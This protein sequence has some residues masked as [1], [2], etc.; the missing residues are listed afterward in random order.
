M[1]SQEFYMFQ[2]PILF[3]AMVL[4][5]LKLMRHQEQNYYENSQIEFGKIMM[6]VSKLLKEAYRNS[7]HLIQIF[8][9]NTCIQICFNLVDFNR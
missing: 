3:W 6:D 9:L 5:N 7:S 4:N 8:I 1:N 2:T